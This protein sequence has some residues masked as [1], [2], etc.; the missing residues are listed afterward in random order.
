M[1][2][3][4]LCIEHILWRIPSI[5]STFDVANMVKTATVKDVP[6]NNDALLN[7]QT[8]ICLGKLYLHPYL[9]VPLISARVPL[10]STSVSAHCQAI[11][12]LLIQIRVI[13]C[14]L[15]NL[16][17]LI[18]YQ[19]GSFR[20]ISI[21]KLF[22]AV[23]CPDVAVPAHAWMRRDG[24]NLMIRCNDTSETWY[25]TCRDSD[26]IG[27]IGNCSSCEYHSFE[28]RKYKQK[29]Y[30]STAPLRCRTAHFSKNK[31]LTIH[32]NDVI[33]HECDGFSSYQRLD[34][35]PSR[36]F[37]LRLK[38]TSKLRV[39]GLCEGNPPVTGRFPLQRASNVENTSVWWRHYETLLFSP[40]WAMYGVSLL[41]WNVA[42]VR[43]LLIP[44]YVQNHIIFHLKYSL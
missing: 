29:S 34:C 36:L 4:I 18:L 28:A 25:L 9:V 13:Y 37:R 24:D 10:I 17:V 7:I 1:W 32:Y 8:C 35:L 12:L 22:S 33:S 40:E 41:I 15:L 5:E 2:I 31:I 21:C 16:D 42:C 6:I 38:K 20:W 27:E 19:V 43:P 23:G 30:K 44:R 3:E 39:T 26:W 11:L 14:N